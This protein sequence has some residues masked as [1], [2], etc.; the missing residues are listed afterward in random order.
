MMNK[1]F[2]FTVLVSLLFSMPLVSAAAFDGNLS[3]GGGSFASSVKVSFTCV[4]KAGTANI[5]VFDKTVKNATVN[6]FYLNGS[7]YE[8]MLAQSINGSTIVSFTP[9]KAGNYELHV[10]VGTSQTNANFFVS[11]CSP[12]PV[13]VTKN[14]TVLSEPKRELIFTKLVNYPDGFSKRFSVYKI[15]TGQVESFES[16]IALSLN[17]A[18]N[19]TKYDFDI[20]DSVPSSVLTRSNQ[21]TFTAQPSARSSEPK[22]EWHVKSLSTGGQLSYS[23][24]FSRPLTEQMIAMFDAPTI[25]ETGAGSQAKQEDSG[26]LAAS[27]GPIFGITFPFMGALFAF[28]VLLAVL[29]FFIFGRKKEEA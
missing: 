21:I 11:S 25:R 17:Y 20:I 15:T 14:N 1:L 3:N 16:N 7:R 6:I 9:G 13:N 10:S 28:L 22:F 2:F 19:S 24:R 27:I 4:G 12:P 18:G 23:Y 26:L 8:K 5:N 29:Y